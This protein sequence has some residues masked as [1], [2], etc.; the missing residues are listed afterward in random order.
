MQR[1]W[2]EFDEKPIS[3]YAQEQLI[4]GSTAASAVHSQRACEYFIMH[5][6]KHRYAHWQI[7][8]DHCSDAKNGDA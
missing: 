3:L 7:A 6:G 5:A 8:E 2:V 4:L 1:E